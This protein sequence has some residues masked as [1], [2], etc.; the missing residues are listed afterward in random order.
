MRFLLAFVLILSA[1]GTQRK[2]TLTPLYQ[3]KNFELKNPRIT[4]DIPIE[5]ETIEPIKFHQ[6]TQ[7]IGFFGTLLELPVDLAVSLIPPIERTTIPKLPETGSLIEPELMKIIKHLSIKKGWIRIVPIAERKDFHQQECFG[8]P[9]P[10]ISLS[11]FLKSIQAYVIF[12]DPKPLP[13]LDR[14]ANNPDDHGRVSSIPPRKEMLLAEATI[15]KNYDYKK[16]TLN[17][18]VADENLRPYFE[19]YNGF[20]IKI[21][22]KVDKPPKRTVYI[23]G[24]IRLDVELDLQK[25]DTVVPATATGP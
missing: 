7:S 2:E 23:D 24:N 6:F 18:N 1:C 9:C 15:E 19:L 25:G 11:D 5:Q 14:K 20:D 8:K 10:D 22:A 13:R 16:K 3:P 17:F 12:K 4:Y 21:I